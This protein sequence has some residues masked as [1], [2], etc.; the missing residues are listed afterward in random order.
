[1]SVRLVMSIGKM[2]I[3]DFVSTVLSRSLKKAWW[4][5]TF[6]SNHQGGNHHEVLPV[7]LHRWANKDT[8][9][10]RSNGVSQSAHVIFSQSAGPGH[11]SE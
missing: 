11:V 6:Y 7:L 2:S 9:N 8:V 1:M 4:L 5:H 10:A 3:K